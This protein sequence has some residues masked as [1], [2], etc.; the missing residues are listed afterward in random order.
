MSE[1]NVYLHSK[2]KEDKVVYGFYCVEFLGDHKTSVPIMRGS[3]SVPSDPVCHYTTVAA[4]DV[5]KKLYLYE[6]DTVYTLA[7]IRDRIALEDLHKCKFRVLKYPRE[8]PFIGIA[9]E[10]SK[11]QV[12]RDSL[13]VYPS[14]STNEVFVVAFVDGSLKE[15]GAYFGYS[16]YRVMKDEETFLFKGVGRLPRSNLFEAAAISEVFNLCVK[17]LQ[18]PPSFI[19]ND[20]AGVKKHVPH[21]VLQQTEIRWLK[22][23]S[24][25]IAQCHKL[26][27]DYSK[28]R[29]QLNFEP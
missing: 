13:V 27:Y 25:R 12:S 23:S 5:M 24:Q 29:G 7:G 8:D 15:D 3:C 28:Y 26:A 14:L 22:R 11:N 2:Q 9:R 18:R 16:V 17:R 21:E 20:C 19:Y 4:N 6:V 10:M 1:I